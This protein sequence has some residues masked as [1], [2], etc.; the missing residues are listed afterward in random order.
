MN[1]R[2]MQGAGAD[3]KTRFIIALALN[4]LM[5]CSTLQAQ[6]AGDNSIPVFKGD[7]LGKAL[8]PAEPL[9]LWYPRPAQKWIEALPEKTALPS[10]VFAV[11][12][13]SIPLA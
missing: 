7:F 13:S 8:P 12:V 11:E 5:L 4:I 2:T 6:S 3:L 9:S 1:N 10:D